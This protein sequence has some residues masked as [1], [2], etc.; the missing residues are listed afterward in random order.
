MNIIVFSFQAQRINSSKSSKDNMNTAARVIILHQGRILLIHRIKFG[1]EYYVLP[2]GSIEKGETPSQAAIR[3]IKEETNFDIK[4]DKLLWKI[5]EKVNGE[6]KLGHYFLAK[7]FNGNL[8]LGGPERGR[9][10]N[11]NIYLFEWVLVT[12]LNDYLL[13]PKGLKEGIIT[14]FS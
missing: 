14:K 2:G 13:Y 1:Q 10:S 3:E 8:K 11:T 7:S 9:Q 12:K 4:L 5:K 6:V